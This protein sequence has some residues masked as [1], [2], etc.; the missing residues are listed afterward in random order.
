M[1]LIR[2]VESRDLDGLEALAIRAGIG[3]TTLPADRQILALKIEGALAAFAKPEERPGDDYYLFV[4]EDSG[5]GRICG[6]T[7][8]HAAVG[9]AEPFYTY[10]LGTV[11]N[12]CDEFHIYNQVP[13]L[14]LGSDF[15]GQTEICTLFLDP[16]YRRDDN[17]KLLS[18]VRFLF[19]AE[20]PERFADKIFAEMR[21]VFDEAGYSPFWEAVG[22]HF[23]HMDF[24]KADYL[25]GIGHKQLITDIMPK[26]PLYVPLLPEAAQV[27]IG[28]VH[29]QTR[30]A[31]Q[32][33]EAEGFRYNGYVDIFD[34]GPTLDV[35]KADIRILAESGHY[36][37]SAITES[38]P[39]HG[40]KMLVTNTRR[41]GFRGGLGRL[42][43]DEEGGV[44][45]HRALAEALGLSVGERL[46]AATLDAQ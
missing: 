34:A 41:E 4:L 21:G 9:L 40:P 33:L 10:K 25:S 13:V 42:S 14:Y 12:T 26:Y 36:T 32:L 37:V 15:T 24:A 46:R 6:T 1:M 19:M 43:L 28:K 7:A 38:E 23:F 45:L 20:H 27:V 18:R 44:L 17:G 5:T 2:P 30:P 35:F 3:M 8:I 22:K 39:S 11:V 29:A 31:R 16:D